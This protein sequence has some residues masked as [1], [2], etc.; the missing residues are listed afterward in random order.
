MYPRIRELVV[1]END[2]AALMALAKFRKE[3]EYSIDR[4]ATQQISGRAV[5]RG[6]LSGGELFPRFRSLPILELHFD[7]A[8][9]SSIT[10]FGVGGLYRAIAAYQNNVTL[11]L[12][13]RP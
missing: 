6:D 7:R 2:R 5:P 11:A 12:L 4:R 3:Q 9:D 13:L 8:V 10:Y 1:K